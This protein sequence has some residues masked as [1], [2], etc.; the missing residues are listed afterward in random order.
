MTLSIYD[1]GEDILTSQISNYLSP[2]DIFKF[3][4]LSKTLYS[5]Y[6]NSSI[7]YQYLYNKKFTNNENNYTLSLQENLNWKQ[8]FYL[9]CNRHQKV[10]TWG[11]SLMGRLG[12][13]LS[14]VPIENRSENFGWMM[15]HTPTNI[16]NFNDHII[17]DIVATGFS[18]II[19]AND[20]ELFFTGNDWKQSHNRATPGPIKTQDYR[21]TPGTM[22]LYTL[23]N[24]QTLEPIR[25]R[26]NIVRGVPPM[27]M[28]NRRYANDDDSDD[29]SGENSDGEIITPDA[30]TTTESTSSSVPPLVP[31]PTSSALPQGRRKITQPEPTPTSTPALTHRPS[32]IKESNFIS[33]LFLP[34]LLPNRKDNLE[35]RKIISIS[36][37]REHIIA[38]DNYNN[39][40]TWDTGCQSNVGVMLEFPGISSNSSNFGRVIKISAGWNL[41]AALIDNYGLIVWYTRIGI[42]EEQFHN[43][44]FISQAKYF[45]IPFTKNDIIDFTVGSNFVMFIRKSDEKLYQTRFNVH[46]IAT[47]EDTSNITIDEIKQFTN[48]MDNFNHWKQQQSENNKENI[49]FTKVT[50]CFNDFSVFTN[51]DQVLL[52]NLHHLEYH[53]NGND[54]GMKPIIIDELQGKNIKRIEIGDYHY[55]A[56]T[57]DGTLLSWGT[58]SRFCGCLGLGSKQS[59][60]DQYTTPTNTEDSDEVKLRGNNLVVLKPLP[61]KPPPYKGKWVCIAASGWH[62][63]GIYVPT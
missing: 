35:K 56:L 62:S 59:I 18:F 11:Q 3:F 16:N 46:E 55:L 34:P 9:R 23:T 7:I 27:P 25:S 1:L 45:I 12:Y 32:K 14:Q 50:G 5:I 13:N 53:D 54:Q 58:E 41:S 30:T 48:P 15:V 8:L 39:I 42:T 10:Y 51:H 2:E 38:L 52:G 31:A 63:G 49:R 6:Q 36:A 40:Y 57:A 61:V 22:A 4:S 37:G 47:R 21:P 44:E 43:R 17:V 28:M 29:S 33:R 24:N 19:L 60:L 20:G 26:R